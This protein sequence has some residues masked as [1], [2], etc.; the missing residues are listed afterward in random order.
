[1]N[2]LDLGWLAGTFDGEGSIGIARQY[3]GKQKTFVLSPQIQMETTCKKTAERIIALLDEHGLVG[4]SYFYRARKPQHRPSYN[5]RIGRLVDA[6]KLSRLLAEVSTTKA[7][8]W[9]LLREYTDRRLEGVELNEEGQVKAGCKEGSKRGDL[10]C[11]PYD[12]REI[13]IYE[14]IKL[15]NKKG[16]E[17]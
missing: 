11:R 4:R 12:E 15:L 13:E 1:M 3:P 6:N 5:I 17:N 14:T 8:Q 10:R 9:K 2:D 16:P 7:E